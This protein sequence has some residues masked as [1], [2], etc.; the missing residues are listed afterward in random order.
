MS[1]PVERFKHW[2]IA[3]CAWIAGIASLLVGP[4][5]ALGQ[6][7]ADRMPSDAMIYVGWRGA[8]TMGAGYQQSHLRAVMEAS[9]V[10]DLMDRFLPQVLDKLI[11]QQPDAAEAVGIL[12]DLAPSLWKHPAA[13][14][15][16]GIT[17]PAAGAPPEIRMAIIVEAGADAAAL[18]QS[19]K[20]V[21]AKA[22]GSPVP[23]T[24]AKFGNFV[25]LS[26]G[27]QA[28]INA[29]VGGPANGVPAKLTARK[30][31]VAAM[32]EAVKD[33]V[34][35]MYLDMD[36]LVALVDKNA[37]PAGQHNPWPAIR[38]GLGLKSMQQFAWSAGFEGKNFVGQAFAVSS[39][40]RTGLVGGTIDAKPISDDLLM[41]IPQSAT[42]AAAG[43]MDLSALFTWVRAMAGKIDPNCA[44][45]V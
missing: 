12:R 2:E 23:I 11:Q 16:G 43:R 15:F 38:D 10:S 19:L 13:F 35:A 42:V 4:L 17:P 20:K 18:E 33:P 39:G 6:P 30:E 7:L 37:G 40:Q 27:P 3:M 31:F 29:L 21:A 24:V 8:D 14:Y 41:S 32:G 22:E 9:N 1:L 44:G 26:P 25:V 28:G 34:A 5:V 36:A 45:A